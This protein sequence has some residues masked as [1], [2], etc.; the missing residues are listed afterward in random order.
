MFGRIIQSIKNSTDSL[1][2]NK[3]R[4]FVTMLGIIIG[5][6]SVVLIMSIGAGAQNL[7]LS[8]IQS[9]GG[10]AV[11]VLPGH[12]EDGNPFD[13]LSNFSVTTL[14]YDDAL[15]LQN[16][17]G[18]PHLT[19]VAGY[20]KGFAAVKWRSES[21]DT[22]LTGTMASYLDVE[23][24]KIE[25]GRFFTKEEE[26]NLSRVVVLGSAVKEGLFQESD[27]VGQR[28]K[29]KDTSY[30]VIG[31]IEERGNFGPAEDADDQVV[32]PLKTAQRALGVNHLGFMRIRIDSDENV[33]ESIADIKALLREQHDIRDNTGKSDDFT[34]NSSAQ[35]L[36]L[37]TAI[38][39]SVRYFLTAMAAVSLIVG[40]IG[41]MNI[42]L[43]S[44]TERTREIGLRKAIGAN[45]TNIMGQ[46]LLESIFVTVIGGLI[47]VLSGVFLSFVISV[48]IKLSGFDWQ[49][50]ILPS[51][52]FLAIV[53]ST[54][55]GLVF[56]FYPARKASKLDPIEA[57]HYE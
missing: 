41:I 53:V 35:A 3:A 18:A 51:S 22:S 20:T 47:G 19:F 8:Q 31:V 24:A 57:L 5:V 11:V 39:D 27:A 10:N 9:I 13:V 56:G 46:F 14:K 7:I 30:E 36:G 6:G 23:H 49:L 32:I 37:V 43:I 54:I 50:I 16:N 38:T 4:S 26:R 33:E 42:M 40:G 25:D 34:V 29:I 2:E 12:S 17:R 28:I 1:W 21:Y 55:V 52:I 44:V 45:N 48:G 15:Y